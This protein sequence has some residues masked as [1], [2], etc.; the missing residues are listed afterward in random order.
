MLVTKKLIVEVWIFLYI[1]NQFRKSNKKLEL[2]CQIHNLG[3]ETMIKKYV[4]STKKVKRKK[5]LSH[6]NPKK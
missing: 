3:H 2:T 1:K 6:H 5:Y 4:F